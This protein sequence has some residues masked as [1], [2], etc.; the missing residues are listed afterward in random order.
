MGSISA[1]TR[2]ELNV[3]YSPDRDSLPNN[4]ELLGPLDSIG[5]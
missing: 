2:G 5:L 1:K 4:P 3:R